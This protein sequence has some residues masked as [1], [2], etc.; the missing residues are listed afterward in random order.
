MTG[1]G[2]RLGS[3]RRLLRGRVP[4]STPST[5][6]TRRRATSSAGPTVTGVGAANGSPRSRR[7]AAQ[8]LSRGRRGAPQLGPLTSRRVTHSGHRVSEVQQ[9]GLRV[10][11]SPRRVEFTACIVSSRPCAP[12]ILRGRAFLGRLRVCTG[13]VWARV[14]WFR[15]GG[16][17]LHAMRDF[18]GYAL[19]EASEIS[20][21][22]R[23]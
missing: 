18:L 4:R 21:S 7:V 6:R 15:E 1:A 19:R 23:V 16:F 22:G 9:V 17:F 8:R 2:S 5:C 13:G 14:P 20:Y 3:C 12:G 11:L 10:F